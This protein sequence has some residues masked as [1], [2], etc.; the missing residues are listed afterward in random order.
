MASKGYFP[1]LVDQAYE[2]DASDAKV[3]DEVVVSL[4]TQ[5]GK[6][7]DLR[8]LP[9]VHP[10]SDHFLLLVNTHGHDPHLVSPHC[11][12][13]LQHLLVVLHW[14]LAGPTP[15]GPNIHQQ[16]LS[17]FVLEM[18][19]ALIKNVIN[20][21]IISEGASSWLGLGNISFYLL[22][23]KGFHYLAVFLLSDALAD[24]A[25]DEAPQPMERL[26]PEAPLFS[27]DH[28]FLF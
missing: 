6:V 10:C 20:F 14:S 23:L 11:L 28:C 26:S 4:P 27:N 2:G 21:S 16:N 8:P 5:E 7:L 17:G 1:E 24:G 19:L 25:L 12:I 9:A 3:L 18:R 22:F 13:L 15:S